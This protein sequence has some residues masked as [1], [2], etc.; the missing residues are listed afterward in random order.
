MFTVQARFGIMAL[1]EIQASKRIES[2]WNLD[3]VSNQNQI[4]MY[5]Q[6]PG[7]ALL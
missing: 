6:N 4:S 1:Y 3:L 7:L 5:C 2:K